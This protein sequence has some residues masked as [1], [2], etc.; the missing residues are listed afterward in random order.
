MV[1]VRSALLT[2]VPRATGGPVVGRREVVSSPRGPSSD[3]ANEPNRPV[4]IAADKAGVVTRSN[5]SIPS[6]LASEDRLRTI[7]QGIA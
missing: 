4:A 1:E 6:H 3:A 7:T 5:R 2:I